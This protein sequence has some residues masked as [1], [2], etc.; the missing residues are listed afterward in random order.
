MIVSHLLHTHT[1]LHGAAVAF[2]TTDSLRQR[3]SHIVSDWTIFHDFGFTPSIRW[4]CGASLKERQRSTELRG[5][6]GVEAVV[7]VRWRG[8]RKWNGHVERN[9][10]TDCVKACAR[11]A[12]DRKAP[13]DRPRK[14]WQNTVY[15]CSKLTPGTSTTE[16]N[17][18]I[19][20]GIRRTQQHLEHSLLKPNNKKKEDPLFK[21][22]HHD[23]FAEITCRNIPS[24]REHQ[25]Q[26]EKVYSKIMKLRQFIIALRAEISPVLNKLWRC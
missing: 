15:V 25:R 9:G 7:V 22:T 6:L 2:V 24:S 3:S 21:N 8:R 1:P 18:G 19:F 17:G 13:V 23:P 10:D 20:D 14:T 26:N 4:M 12:V 5:H 16:W 11:L